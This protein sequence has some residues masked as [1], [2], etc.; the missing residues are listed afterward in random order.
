VVADAM[1]ASGSRT[2]DFDIDRHVAPKSLRRTGQSRARRPCSSA[3]GELATTPLDP[4]GRCGSST[5]SSDYEGG[6]A[7]IAAS[8]TA[9]A[10]ALR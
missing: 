5:W 8:T 7:L 10:T 2:N 3:C 4:R 6:S 9:S 1:G